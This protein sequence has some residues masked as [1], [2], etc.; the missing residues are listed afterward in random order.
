[1]ENNILAVC[2]AAYRAGRWIG[3][4]IRS[5]RSQELPDGWTLDLRIGTDGCG[6]TEKA[7]ADL[8]EPYYRSRDNH[9]PYI[10]RNSLLALRRFD[11][12]LVFDADDVMRPGMIKALL[13]AA[14]KHGLASPWKRGADINL[15]PVKSPSRAKGISMFTREVWE[16]MGGFY[17]ER[18]SM[19]LEFVK[20]AEQ[21]GY[22]RSWP[23]E[24][25]F[26]RRQHP[27]SLTGNKQTAVGSMY[28][29]KAKKRAAEDR[30]SRGLKKE[31]ITV[32]M[33]FIDGGGRRGKTGGPEEK[34]KKN[35]E[36]GTDAVCP[37]GNGSR[38]GDKE[39]RYAVK[40]LQKNVKGLRDLI[41]V[42]KKPPRNLVWRTGEIRTIETPGTGLPRGD[43]DII[44]KL[45]RAC[46][47]PDITDPFLMF[48]DDHYV[49]A[50][51]RADS[52]PAYHKPS[53]Q[54]R[55]R[56]S[57]YRKRADCTY[58]VIKGLGVD[59]PEMFD[60]HAPVLIYKNDYL[61]SLNKVK[62]K[63]GK[64]LCKSV[65]ANLCRKLRRKSLPDC[66]TGQAGGEL[67]S[68]PWFS[69]TARVHDSLWKWMD[70]KLNEGSKNERGGTVRERLPFKEYR[71]K[72]AEQGRTAD[73]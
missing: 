46:G 59:R 9:G 54:C 72:I 12:A 58:E 29:Q 10:I 36:R 51:F 62:W 40:F 45:L 65:Y 8:N 47:D 5:V 44:D 21:A 1:M 6:E 34:Q 61:E 11:A 17:P 4:S 55:S 43:A 30:R 7:L 33:E 56:N 41:V 73:G 2:I 53:W 28:R 26:D 31:L 22:R 68:R 70:R 67:E 48:H 64:I 25:V 19:D 35:G 49:L 20:R 3:D 13:P 52:F 42:G 15:K 63:S 14:L 50:Q 38:Y 66:K 23:R 60:L 39:L 71:K 57:E 18:V 37:L 32:P 27:D 69:T 24:A 16:Q